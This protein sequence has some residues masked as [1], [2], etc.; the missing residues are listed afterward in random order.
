M[1]GPPWFT[2]LLHGLLS[3]K[4]HKCFLVVFLPSVDLES[5]RCDPSCSWHRFSTTSQASTRVCSK[6]TRCSATS[7]LSCSSRLWPGTFST[8]PLLISI[9][10]LRISSETLLD[11]HSGRDTDPN[12][13][14]A[15]V[16]GLTVSSK[17]LSEQYNNTFKF[18]DLEIC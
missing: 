16:G 6:R 1:T 11:W 15:V 2:D 18:K 7:N 9:W 17:G 12:I 13:V 8:G 4:T 5:S 14:V 3:D 10:S